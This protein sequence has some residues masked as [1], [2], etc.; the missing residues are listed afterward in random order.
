MKNLFLFMAITLVGLG[1][2]SEKR[3]QPLAI[4]NSLTQEEIAAGVLS[5]EVMWKMG[6]VGLAS[7]SP[8]ASRL[9][10]TVTWYNMQENRGV[11][12]IYVRDAASGEVAQL[13]D[14]SSNNSDP[15]WNA[16]GSKIYFLSDRSGSSQIW[17][18]GADGQNPRQLS[19]LEKDIEGFGVN[20]AGDK[21]FYVQGVQVADRKSSDIHPDMAESKA[22]VYDDL[23]CRHWDR[24][25]EGEYRHIF[26]ADL[27]SGGIGKGVD[28]IGEGAE[29]DTPLAPYFDMSEIAWAPD[30]TRLAY[31]CKPLTG[32]KYAVSTDSDIFVYD[33]ETGATTNICKGLTPISGHDAAAK[34]ELPFVGY[35]KYPVFSPDGTKIAFR[36]Q[37][38]A[39]NE[40]DKERLMVWNSET[41]LVKE[42]TKNFDY[43][44]TNVIWD[45]SEALWFLAPMEATHQL[46]RVDMNGNVS[47][48]TRGDHDINAVSIANGKA[49]ADICTI[50]S[51]S[52]L[53][54]IDLKD[55]A[56]T[57]LTFINQPILDKIRLGKVEKRWV[58]TTDGKQMLT[59]V[60]LPPDF[61]PAKKYP[62]LL[63]CEG[64]PQSVVSQ[65]W[66]YRWNFQLMAA[67]GY[68]VVAPNRRGVP[69]FGQEW[70]DQ[71]SGDYS[72]QNI[73]DYLSAIDD[74]AKEPWVDK[75]R[76][77]CVG[78]SYGGYSVYFLAGHHDG[79]FKAFI[80]HCGIFDFEA[81]YGSTEELFFLNNDYGGPYWDKQNATAMRT[82]ANS[83][84]KFVDKWDTTIMIITATKQMASVKIDRTDKPFEA[85]VL[86]K[87][88]VGTL[89]P[90]AIPAPSL[91]WPDQDIDATH[92]IT[93]GPDQSLTNPAAIDITVPGGIAELK[94]EIV[95]D[96]LNSLGIQ[97]LDLVHETSIAGSIQYK[98]LGL[99]CS[100]EIQYTKSTVFDITK[101]VPMIA[102][103]PDAI[104]NHVFKV[105]VTDL[106]GQTTV[107]DLTFHYG[108]V[109]LETADLWQ[110]TATLKIVP[111]ATAASATLEYKRSTDDAW[112]QATVSDNGNGTFTA[113][114]EP[115][116]SSSTN[117]MGKTVY[118]P[119]YATGVFAGTTYDYRLKLDGAEKETGR[120][121]TA[122]GDVIP[123]A[124][125]SEWST[126]SRA[127]LSGSSDVPYPNK[128]GDSF[129]D[130]GNNGVTTGLCSST[131]DKFGAAAPAAKLQSQNMFVLASGNLFT[132]SFNYASF[133]GT[134]NFGS[135]YTYTAR[136]RA[137]RVKY[138]ATTGNIDMVRSQ[139]P[140]PGVAKGDPDKCRIFVAIVDWTQP[141]TVVSGMSSTTGAWDP[142]NGA[143]VVSEGKVVG[144]GSMWI[145]QS[146]PGEALVS[147]EDALKIHWYEEKAPAP[148]GDYTIVISCAANAYG[149]YMTGYSE[150]CLYVDDFEWVY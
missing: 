51:P 30:G 144:Y 90:S 73:R 133:T 84:H 31:T 32:A 76:L 99:K 77:G 95:S 43:N 100:T 20:P 91:D 108:Q 45:G 38:R 131:T 70:L 66:S 129:W 145:N 72:G 23:M 56:L 4:D 141:H 68:I 24:W 33:T 150:A 48:L 34:T 40:A 28:I 46:C 21:V 75:D 17:E 149:D 118:E 101:L 119:D 19:K 83:P 47:V 9:L 120:F 116:W 103:L 79:R 67:N 98:D 110:N 87:K 122:K 37:R 82:Y 6:R 58:E 93:V 123:N 115:T 35:D 92:E 59:W 16:D 130:C 57:Q 88:E 44:A 146:T 94:V 127:G 53:Y 148:T 78:A 111:S 42:L 124:D 85:G 112:Q 113:A 125:M 3:S 64:G 107:Q 105:S 12:A 63:Y 143:D 134:V 147:S 104:G 142:T 15:K 135:K 65:F 136:P 86:Y 52:E 61:D 22:R 26:I 74:V 96:A 138:H 18:M 80:S 114:I 55:G 89:T 128:N 25:D 109:T 60:I 62:T 71:I 41:G 117:E 49:V 137:L 27:T 102:M 5:P 13:T 7:L 97:N 10:Y 50:S 54:E 2:C 139:E 11:T 121:T 14:F 29:W 81:M 140:A 1:G 106:A 69:S 126:V 132:G 39:G 36:S 8:D